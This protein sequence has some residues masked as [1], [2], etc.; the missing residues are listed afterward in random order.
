MLQTLNDNAGALQV[1]FAAFVT[2]ATIVYA[3]L[4][5]S[6]VRETRR[7]RRAQTD[8]K[9]VIGLNTRSEQI[10]LVD[11][12]I[13]NEGMG[14]AYDVQ[15]RA[16]PVGSSGYAEILESIRSLGFIDQGLE[17]FSPGQEIRS[18]LTTMVGDFEEKL[19]TRIRVVVD[20]TTASGEH[21]SD[22]YVLDL[23]IFRGLHQLG[24]PDLY[25]IA[26][27]LKSVK[28]DI[29]HLTTGFHKLQVITQDK[30]DYRREQE[31]LRE[32]VEERDRKHQEFLSKRNP[33]Q[34]TD[35]TG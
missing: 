3:V 1:V 8:A 6:L 25:S 4:T 28:D 17:Y 9:M 32:E 26:E 19:A 34:E 16:E 18:F 14:P 5:W 24:T 27:S 33:S 22:V 35:P 10:N 2:L 11:V 29:R 7:M 30:A 13:R 12:F 20:Y 15:F 31:E 21:K 23:S